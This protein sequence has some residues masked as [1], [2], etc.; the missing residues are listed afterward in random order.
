[1]GAISGQCL[2]FQQGSCALP[3]MGIGLL[4]TV[5]TLL[6]TGG[7]LLIRLG[8]ADVDYDPAF[9]LYMAT[10]IANPHFLPEACI[11]VNLVNFT[12]TCKVR[13]QHLLAC[14]GGCC[15]A[16]ATPQYI[17][18]TRSLCKHGEP[19]PQM[20]HS[21]CS[22]LHLFNTHLPL[23]T[24]ANTHTHGWLNR[25]WRTSCWVSWCAKSAPN[26]RSSAT[27]WWSALQPT[28]SSWCSWRTGC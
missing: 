25:A 16:V 22:S 6:Y 24:P 13:V 11:Q 1:M 14:P 26:W 10:S 20:R 7:R 4:T 17:L 19:V 12:V 2:V 9:K 15:A 8:D 28:R 5:H 23:H 18:C 3:G 21:R 27:A